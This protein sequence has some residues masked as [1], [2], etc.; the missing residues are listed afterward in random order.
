[1]ISVNVKASKNYDVL[2]GR[3]ILSVLSEKLEK[4][5]G[6][7][8]VMVVTDSTVYSLHYK[9]IKSVLDNAGFENDVFVFPAG[10]HSKSKEVLFDLLETLAEK[11]FTKADVLV[12]FGGGVTGDLT[13]LA[14]SLFL[15]GIH[16][17]QV[18]TTLLSAVD[19]SVGGKT[20]V[21]L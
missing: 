8:K 15:R 21:N 6:N 12:A 14:A 9:K 7:V 3:N 2:I 16:V 10:E 5:F 4:L 11:H 13:G 17:V 20:A 1:M 19:S 18:P